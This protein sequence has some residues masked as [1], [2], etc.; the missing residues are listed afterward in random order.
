MA[1]SIDFHFNLEPPS[2]LNVAV[3]TL[4]SPFPLPIKKPNDAYLEPLT[5][6]AHRWAEIESAL[7][8]A[9]QLAHGAGD[10]A[11][12]LLEPSD[13][14][15]RVP[16]DQM[17]DESPTLQNANNILRWSSDGDRNLV[18]TSVLDVRRGKNIR[19]K[20]PTDVHFAKDEVAYSAF[21][22]TV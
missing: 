9:S 6:L 22:E 11:I 14:A 15:E 5:R 13:P 3:E 10:L 8:N 18:N 21:E 16:Y 7:Q 1:R 20:F 2:G 17:V 19:D 12:L 4:R